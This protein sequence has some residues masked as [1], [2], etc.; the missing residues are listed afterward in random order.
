MDT[1]DFTPDLSALV[2]GDDTTNRSAGASATSDRTKR[3][4]RAAPALRRADPVPRREGASLYLLGADTRPLLT[5][6]GE[7]DLAR[8]IQEGEEAMLRALVA[9]PEALREL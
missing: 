4:R 8:R 9:S 3:T 5:R 2:P 1:R 7:H 6:E